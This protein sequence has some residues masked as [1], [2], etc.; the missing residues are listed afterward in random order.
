MKK[1]IVETNT[2]QRNKNYKEPRRKENKLCINVRWLSYIQLN[3]I[4][5]VKVYMCGSSLGIFG[6]YA[7]K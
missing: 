2:R 5:F 6:S 1:E 3:Q 7:L 4:C